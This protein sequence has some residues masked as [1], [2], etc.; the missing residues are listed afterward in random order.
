MDHTTII[1]GVNHPT[2]IQ[3][4]FVPSE[5]KE[6]LIWKNYNAGGK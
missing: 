1:V 3:K 6:V 5:W 4:R 2:S